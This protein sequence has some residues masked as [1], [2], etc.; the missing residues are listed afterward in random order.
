VRTEHGHRLVAGCVALATLLLTW[1]VHTVQA[2]RTVRRLALAAAVTV[3]VQA[4]LGGLRVLHLSIDLAMIHGWLGQIFF[5]IVVTIAVVTSPHWQR[6]AHEPASTSFAG[7]AVAAVTL[8]IAQLVVGILIR[9]AGPAARPLAASTLFYF[10]LFGAGAML[11]VA[12]AMKAVAES[13][14]GA[15]YLARRSRLLLV[16]VTTQIG[17]GVATWIATEG[18]A[19]ARSTTAL[20]AWLPTFHVATG[21]GVLAISVTL[22]LHALAR[23]SS[24]ASVVQPHA[25]EMS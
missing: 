20:E 25:V 16:L 17:L 19:G 12:F 10:H 3:L 5:A 4:I 9:H 15:G 1:R 6:R 22:A 23:T 18:S 24:A 13:S 2:G 21:A 7:L 14:S 8:V 11:A